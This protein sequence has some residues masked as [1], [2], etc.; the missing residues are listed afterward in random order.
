M[1]RSTLVKCILAFGI[2]VFV[3][4]HHASA[5]VVGTTT[6]TNPIPNQNCSVQGFNFDVTYDWSNGAPAGVGFT[7]QVL[8]NGI[9]RAGPT[10]N[11]RQWNPTP[12]SIRF[13]GVMTVNTQFPNS[14]AKFKVI[15]DSAGAP[16][17]AAA[18]QVTIQLIP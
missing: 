14:P 15:P 2:L 9:D 5:Q 3:G 1:P 8:V 11:L 16:L 13:T 7:L 18:K 12:K 4:S 6:I 17:N 10:N